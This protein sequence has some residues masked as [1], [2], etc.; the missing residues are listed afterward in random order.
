VTTSHL[1]MSWRSE[2]GKRKP[3]AELGKGFLSGLLFGSNTGTIVPN[4]TSR[5]ENNNGIEEIS[6]WIFEIWVMG[7][8]KSGHLTGYGACKKEGEEIT[9]SVSRPVSCVH[10][11]GL[12][13]LEGNACVTETKSKEQTIIWSESRL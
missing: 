12:G 11:K 8:K 10:V 9:N 5:R 4:G 2:G 7:I 13:V 3:L 1:T 6:S